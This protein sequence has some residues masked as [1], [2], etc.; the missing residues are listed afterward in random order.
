MILTGLFAPGEECSAAAA[1]G[2]AYFFVLKHQQSFDVRWCR[3]NVGEKIF[4]PWIAQMEGR[5]VEFI[6][7]TRA[8]D[9]AT[10]A[11]TGALTAVKCRRADGE[12]FTLDGVSDVVFAVGA[13]A[14]S[15]LVRGSPSLAQ[16]AEWRRFANLRGLSVLAT[17]LFLDRPV[18]TAYTANA[19]WGFDEGVGMT[20]FDIKRLHAPAYD[21]EGSVLEVDFYHSNTLLVMSDEDIVAKAKAHLDTMLGGACAAASVVDAAVVRLPNAVNWYYPN[22][23]KDMPDLRSTA[24]PNAYFVGDLV[25]T[26]HGSWSQEK[27]FVTGKQAANVMLGRPADDGVVPLKPDEVHVD[28]GRRAV[29]LARGLLGGGDAKRGPSLVDFLW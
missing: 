15:G 28:A 13:S 17:R 22:S 20:F 23:Y 24:V 4:A 26:R 7:S 9:F 19:C 8:T 16:H 14:L 21:G 12:E 3:G 11:A 6:Q 29:G 1:L 18:P 27:A 2:M 25:R 10:D 5:G